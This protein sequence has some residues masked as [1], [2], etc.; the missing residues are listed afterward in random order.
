MFVGPIETEVK[1]IPPYDCEILVGDQIK[2]SFQIDG[3]EIP[4]GKKTTKRAISTS[5]RI[6]LAP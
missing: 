4:K 3:E 5:Q 6:E 1:A 2:T